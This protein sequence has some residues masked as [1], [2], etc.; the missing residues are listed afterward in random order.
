MCRT[1]KTTCP[2]C[3]GAKGFTVFSHVASGV[4]FTCHGAG[5]IDVPETEWKRTQERNAAVEQEN[6]TKR[7]WLLNAT[8]KAI[9]GLSFAQLLKARDFASACISCG[10]RE[11]TSAHLRIMQQIERIAG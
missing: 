6:A 2:K 7:N 11:L 5:V 4:C 1:V 9:A 10:E 3:L 8:D